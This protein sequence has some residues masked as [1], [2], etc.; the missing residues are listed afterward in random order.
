MPS[1]G[2]AHTK[3]TLGGPREVGHKFARRRRRG[4]EHHRAAQAAH[5]R[6]FDGR[7]IGRHGH[8]ADNVRDL[9]SSGRHYACRRNVRPV[10][11]GVGSAKPRV[12]RIGRNDRNVF[13]GNTR[14]TAGGRMT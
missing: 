4:R 6:E 1:C 9:C 14:Q 5:E 2:S 11:M 13:V 10:G 3:Y 8:A 12:G 7:M